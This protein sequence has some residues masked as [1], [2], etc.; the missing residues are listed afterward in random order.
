MTPSSILTTSIY[1][2][3]HLTD[4][5]PTPYRYPTHNLSENLLWPEPVSGLLD[6]GYGAVKSGGGVNGGVSG[7]ANGR[8]E[9]G[10]GGG[11]LEIEGGVYGGNG[12]G[13]NYGLAD[14]ELELLDPSAPR[15]LLRLGVVAAATA[16]AVGFPDF[17]LVLS[18]IG[19]VC[20]MTICFILPAVMHMA[21]V[22]KDVK[23]SKE[24]ANKPYAYPVFV[25]AADVLII[26]AGCYGMVMG[27]V[28]T[29]QSQ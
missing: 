6:Q 9:A 28:A 17:A 16:I 2:Y 5:P 13:G 3:Q 4:I 8:V 14:D 12:S 29:L 11:Q 7:G 19:C 21:C 24:T 15:P 18:L 1:P 10:K 27:T 20:D 22:F 23:E 26:I 25:L